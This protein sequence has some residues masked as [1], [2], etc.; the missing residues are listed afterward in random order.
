VLDL[1]G[2]PRATYAI[3]GAWP[4]V[5]AA[6]TWSRRSG[7]RVAMYT[8]TELHAGDVLEGD[9]LA[10]FVD[11]QTDLGDLAQHFAAH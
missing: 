11:L 3:S 7:R 10:S 4:A 1:P 8:A 6:A 9:M 5:A 2:E